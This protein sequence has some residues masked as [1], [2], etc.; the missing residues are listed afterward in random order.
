M[1]TSQTIEEKFTEIPEKT[2]I[3]DETTQGKTTTHQKISE[4]PAIIIPE[5][6]TQY[7]T[8]QQVTSEIGILEEHTKNEKTTN[9]DQIEYLDIDI[10]DNIKTG[11]R[12]GHIR[13]SSEQY[14]TSDIEIITHNSNKYEKLKESQSQ[15][16]STDFLITTTEKAEAEPVES[17]VDI[18]TEYQNLAKEERII[19]E[20]LGSQ[21][22]ITTEYQNLA[23]EKKNL[24]DNDTK[25]VEVVSETVSNDSTTALPIFL[26]VNK[27][28]TALK[29]SEEESTTKNNE[30]EFTNTEVTL[31]AIR[32]KENSTTLKV[33]K[34]ED[35]N[36]YIDK[37]D[38]TTKSGPN[39]INFTTDMPIN[40]E[41]KTLHLITENEDHLINVEST[42]LEQ[43]ND[44]AEIY[45]PKNEESA[46]LKQ[47]NKEFRRY[48]Y[49]VNDTEEHVTS[50]IPFST[51]PITS[52]TQ[53]KPAR[54]SETTYVS[55]K[56]VSTKT[57]PLPSM[58][59]L[60]KQQKPVC[61]QLGCKSI[62]TRMLSKINHAV[63]P[64]EDFYEYAC[65][66]YN[67]DNDLEEKW[68]RI[69]K[70]IDGVSSES[71]PY[72]QT[73]KAVYDNCVNF[74]EDYDFE[75]RVIKGNYLIF[76]Y[77]TS[78]IIAKAQDIK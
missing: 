36:V 51:E 46:T 68:R 50:D 57:T 28:R 61:Q 63:D 30:N 10:R 38:A 59:S 34:K 65:G 37:N 66:N 75:D 35:N 22:D 73:F 2:I 60:F 21:V 12:M 71:A 48:L 55:E 11:P 15:Q 33:M 14:D 26:Q 7:L 20:P 4:N 52:R 47:N 32:K 29:S 24:I 43:S 6:T 69:R 13:S 74:H 72:L 78:K 40:E 54:N 56:F 8:V 53:R 9:Y 45:T 44:A 17:Q 19:A 18:V 77:C 23:L 42:T 67:F 70:V 5:Q 76:Y 25:A 41:S 16:I 1:V 3:I 49:P 62:S 58:N 31:D 39:N 27:N 64:C